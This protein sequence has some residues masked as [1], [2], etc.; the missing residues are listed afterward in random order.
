[1]DHKHILFIVLAFILLPSCMLPTEELAKIGK[2]PEM[3]SMQ[4]PPA[5]PSYQPVVWP[6]RFTRDAQLSYAD[7]RHSNSLW[8]PTARAFFRAKKANRVGDILKV[9]VSVQDRAELENATTSSRNNTEDTQAPT[10]LGLQDKLKYLI[11][12][13]AIDPTDL[14]NLS[15]NNTHNGQGTVEREEII[16]T[17]IAATVTQILPNGNLVVHGDQEIRVNSEIRKITV[18]G[19]VRPEDIA[20]D[21]S[22]DSNLI[23][24]ARISYGGRGQ[25]TKV[26]QPRYGAQVIDIISPF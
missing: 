24:Q 17:E 19:I 7:K 6:E 3:D 1:M 8:D 21:N 20:A 5:K 14:I 25:L 16:N 23:A 26:Q 13:A 9:M 2:V 22:V 4:L 12:G 11:P 10:I 15:T 18:D